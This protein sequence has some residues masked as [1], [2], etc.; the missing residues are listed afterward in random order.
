[1]AGWD[2][3]YLELHE[4]NHSGWHVFERRRVTH[5]SKVGRMT[6]EDTLTQSGDESSGYECFYC[7]FLTTNRKIHYIVTCADVI[8]W[9]RVKT[10]FQN[11][12]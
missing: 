4:I 3:P 5:G 10:R 7:H 11:V 12:I 9:N 1:V 6:I 8:E 2:V